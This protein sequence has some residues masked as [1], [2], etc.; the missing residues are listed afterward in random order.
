MPGS[1]N[2]SGKGNHIL[3]ITP[4]RSLPYRLV[5]VK[6]L[7]RFWSK[8]LFAIWTGS[9]AMCRWTE[10]PRP[11]TCVCENGSGVHPGKKPNHQGPHGPITVSAC[12]VRKTQQTGL[13]QRVSILLQSGI[14]LL[15]SW[16]LV[17]FK[18][19]NSFKYLA[20]PLVKIVFV[21]CWLIWWYFVDCA[22]YVSSRDL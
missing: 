3:F 12:A 11:A 1:H 7:S 14:Q 19:T 18:S 15:S 4:I 20:L 21:I 9:H 6:P 13:F 8:L 22:M 5:L 17:N 16:V 10:C 2:N